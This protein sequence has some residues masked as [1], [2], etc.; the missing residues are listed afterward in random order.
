MVSIDRADDEKEHWLNQAPEARIRQLLY[1]RQLNYGAEATGRLQRVL[2]VV[3][4]S[5]S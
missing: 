1:L 5:S 4:L 3:D 2:E